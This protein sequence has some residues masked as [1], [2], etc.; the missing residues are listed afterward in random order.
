MASG[1]AAARGCAEQDG[2]Q[3]RRGGDQAGMRLVDHAAHQ[4][5]L[6]D[7]RGLVRH[8]AGE[9]ILVARREDQAAVDGDEAARHRKCVD[10]RIAHD[11]VVELMLAFFGAAREAMADLLGCSR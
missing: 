4:M 6:G 11:E 2:G 5:A 8:H 9:L 10:D 3:H 1:I 7:V